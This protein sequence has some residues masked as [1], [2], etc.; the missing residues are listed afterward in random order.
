MGVR[1]AL[2]RGFDRVERPLDRLFGP[3]WNPM[4]NLGTLSWLMFWIV[5]ATGIYLF[6][7]FDTG[8]VNA[9]QSVKWLSE[10]HWLHAG[11]A[12]SLH[13]YASDFLVLLMLVHMVREWA[14]DR[15]RGKRWFSWITGVPVIWFV[16]MSGI[17]GYW[18][19]WDELAQYVALTTTELLDALP[20]FAEP[21]ARNFLTPAS[22]SG[23]FFTL[24][25]FLHIAIPLLLLLMM[26]IHI[27]RITAA[28]T[29]PPRGLSV[30]TL[31]ALVIVSFAMP[32]VLQGPADLARFPSTV[33]LDW[34]ILGLY[35]VIDLV[36][37]SVI[38]TGALLFTVLMFGLPWL[39]PR[40][41]K[42]AAEVFLDF[43]N[44]CTRCEA[45]CPY[46]AI[47]MVPRSDG[48]P[49]PQEALVDPERCVACGICMGSCPSSTPF[50][51]SGPLITGIDL[52]GRPLSKLREEVIAASAD[53]A[54]PGRVMTLACEHGAAAAPEKG[55]VI[56][57]CVAM[58]PPS[59][60]DFILSRDLADGVCIAGCAER[61][62]HN[63][64]GAQWTKE[65]IAR[66][67]DPLLRERVP[68]D[69]LL[70]LWA[71]PTEG[72]R[73]DEALAG[74]SKDVAALEPMPGKRSLETDATGEEDPR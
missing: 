27:Q 52:P 62:C 68:R 35:P 12:R 20:F 23:R 11:L 72:A 71:G 69:R 40:K 42:A 19:V 3:D 57:P 7:F 37:P 10:T 26:W 31:A 39:P 21:I 32:A 43:C 29:M 30:L 66:T 48:A 24:M 45:D 70:T 15:Y 9:Y 74:F 46:T 16:Y 1:T 41:D 13:R 2:K 18:L 5:T 56:L 58:A 64:V 51:R 33:G 8:V 36:P 55:R 14:F 60:F 73:L 17:T 65:R 53:L 54:G 28:R 4:A 22:L 25:V 67:R 34:F 38:W 59:L 44:G 49:F 47:T 61:E 50:R 63:R 6:I